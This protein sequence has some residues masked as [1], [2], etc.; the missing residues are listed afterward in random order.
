MSN[1]Y[2]PVKQP[3]RWRVV[4]DLNGKFIVQE[5]QP[6]WLAL[7]LGRYYQISQPLKDIAECDE[8]VARQ[9]HEA[10]AQSSIKFVVKEY[11]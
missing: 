2:Q 4:R 1:G 7:V 8:F 5:R 6:F 3:A 11:P 9:R 10:A